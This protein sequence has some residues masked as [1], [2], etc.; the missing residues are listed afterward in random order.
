MI[1]GVPAILL[2]GQ[3]DAL[4]DLGRHGVR[5]GVALRRPDGPSRA[6]RYTASWERSPSLWSAGY[7]EW[8]EGLLERNADAVIFPLQES[9]SFWL[10]A[11]RE[12][13]PAHGHRIAVPP[14]DALRIVTLKSELY[15]A[16][17]AHGLAAP[18]TWMAPTV[19]A[20]LAG[21]EGSAFPLVVK[22]Q[23]RCGNRH[24]MRGRLVRNRRELIGAIEW[25]LTNI[26]FRTE[27]SDCWPDISTPLVQESVGGPDRPIT[28]MSGFID[29]DGDWAAL[30]HRKL[31]QFPRRYGNGICFESV[32]LNGALAERLIGMLRSIGFVGM[33]EAE[34]IE[35]GEERLL[36]DLN[37]RAFNGMTLSLARGLNPTWWSYLVATG[38]GEQVKQEMR[39]LRMQQPRLDLVY[40]R[41]LEFAATL[42]GQS[43]LCGFGPRQIVDWG[44]WYLRNRS[45][46]VDPFIADDDPHI[47]RARLRTQLNA[48]RKHPRDFIGTYVRRGSGR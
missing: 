9:D 4:H 13:H 14:F 27:V 25:A 16:S 33:F 22:P 34:F 15:T 38:A 37:P 11:W 44:R 19:E 42:A 2:E 43:I 45:V 18:R 26:R 31:L 6:S 10:A 41:K 30:A 29:R 36:I 21:I 12:R 5:V 8:F 7:S 47:G 35:R 23:S 28:N 17:V 40:C 20:A 39:A 48:W 24:W 3:M 32:P 1:T 46:M